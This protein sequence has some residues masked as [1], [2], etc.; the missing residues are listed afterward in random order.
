M[1]VLGKRIARRL[2]T[3]RYYYNYYF[4]REATMTAVP[5][6]SGHKRIIAIQSVVI[7]RYEKTET[8]KKT[9]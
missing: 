9:Q 6:P 8:K 7:R 5:P 3:R 1:T 4:S 2:G